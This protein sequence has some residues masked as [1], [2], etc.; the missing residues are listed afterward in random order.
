MAVVHIWA[1]G[2]YGAFRNELYFLVCGWHPAFGYVDQPPL[3]PLIAAATQVAGIHVALLRLPAILAAVALVPL[4]VAF[5]Q[6]LGAG[7]RGAWLAAVANASAT[8]LTAMFANLS[9]STFEPLTFT[10]VAYL[11]AR[12][13]LRDEPGLYKWAGLVAGLSFETRYGILMWAVGLL[14]GILI[15]G[16]RSILRSR[17]LWIGAGIAALIALPNAI[18]QAVHGFPF[19]ELVRNDNSGNFIG[20][21]AGFVLQQVLLLNVV[22]AP[23]WLTGVFAPFF[24]ARLHPARFLSIAFIVTAIIVLGSHGKAYYMSAAYPTMF[25]VGAAAV[26][27]LWRWVV[28][29]WA[30]LAA[31]NAIPALPFVMALEPPAKLKY[32]IDHSP[33]KMPPMERAGIGA[34]LMQTLSD[35]FGWRELGQTVTTVYNNLPAQQRRAAAIWA[36]N[37][38]EASAIDVYG[39]G[40]PP[41]LSGNNQFYLWG[42]HGFDGSVVLAVN[43]DPDEWA[44]LC[45]SSRVV[46][47]FGTSPY[48]MPYET[49]RPIV[50][51]LGMHEPLDRVWP[52]FKQY[53]IENLGQRPVD[54]RRF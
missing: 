22:L 45:S 9:T 23:L 12:A 10:A 33:F 29:L 46:A 24:S 13:H 39:R 31:L 1:G 28:A 11:I 43:G 21:P 37:Y 38:G 30:V 53:G 25:A 36:S 15:A 47:T 49:H 52:R 35:Q 7:T 19:L 20:T 14:A 44:Q 3:V 16:P 18:W 5:A 2:H 26:T 40:L 8:M 32:T 51:C 48:A 54:K 42:T 41:A 34:P 27:K 50:L 6:L 17:D 4:T